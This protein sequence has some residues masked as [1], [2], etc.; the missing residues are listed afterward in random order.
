MAFHYVSKQSSAEHKEDEAKTQPK[1][2][3]AQQKLVFS[4]CVQ[5]HSEHL[6]TKFHFQEKQPFTQKG[7]RWKM[8]KMRKLRNAPFVFGFSSVKERA[9]T[10]AQ[11][12]GLFSETLP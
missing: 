6:I 2:G 1:H 11:L 9:R 12:W 10:G 3:A 8:R 7:E 5:T 4:C